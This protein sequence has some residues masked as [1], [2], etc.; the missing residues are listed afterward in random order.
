M[1]KHRRFV[2]VRRPA[3]LGGKKL[4]DILNRRNAIPARPP[5]NLQQV[6]AKRGGMHEAKFLRPH[7]GRFRHN[8]NLRR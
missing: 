7:A 2:R 8:V 5:D 1:R 4:I 6:A 3:A